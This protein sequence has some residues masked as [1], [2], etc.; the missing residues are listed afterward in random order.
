MPRFPKYQRQQIKQRLRDGAT[1]HFHKS[2]V[3]NGCMGCFLICRHPKTTGQKHRLNG[4]S[5]GMFH[6]FGFV[7]GPF[8]VVAT[9]CMQRR[10]GREQPCRRWR[11]PCPFAAAH[12]CLLPSCDNPTSPKSPSLLWHLFSPA[13]HLHHLTLDGKE[14]ADVPLAEGTN[15][16]LPQ[17]TGGALAAWQ[18][19]SL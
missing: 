3:I 11:H 13:T 10:P 9:S 12:H 2:L 15:L 4:N 14:C 18:S 5:H 8:K 1:C 6:I 7:A 17:S 19:G 16:P